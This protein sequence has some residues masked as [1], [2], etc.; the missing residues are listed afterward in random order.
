M[1]AAERLL[2]LALSILLI[3]FLYQVS[4]CVDKDANCDLSILLIGFFVKRKRFVSSKEDELSIL[5]IGFFT[6][7]EVEVKVTSVAFQFFLLDSEL[8]L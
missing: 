1:G 4:D 2:E 7:L 5:L 3:G 8:D 6:V